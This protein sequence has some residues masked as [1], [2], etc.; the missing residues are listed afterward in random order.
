MS[1][2]RNVPVLLITLAVAA[3]AAAQGQGSLRWRN[4]APLG[5]QAAGGEVRVPCASYTL[6][7]GDA[8][9]LPL[10]ASQRSPRAVSMQLSSDPVAPRLVPARDP[11]MQVNVVGTAGLLED[12]GVYGRIGTTLQRATP[13]LAMP[14]GSDGGLTYGVGFS[15][16]F[17]R[18]GSAALGLDSYDLRGAASDGREL[19][20]SLGLQW[21]Y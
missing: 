13:A 16:D 20:T 7:C 14:A 3:T 17:S 5:L 4:A 18:R 1:A 11:G 15:W 2:K 6:S 19:R 9:V 8:A 10:Y 21:R 12:L